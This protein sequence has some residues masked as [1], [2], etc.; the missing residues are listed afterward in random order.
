MLN[1][2]KAA[3][4]TP[5]KIILGVVSSVL[6]AVGSLVMGLGGIILSVI[7]GS[8]SAIMKILN[9]PLTSFVGSIIKSLLGSL[10]KE[11]FKG[12]VSLGPLL[13]SLTV[14]MAAALGAIGIGV[15]AIGSAAYVQNQ[16]MQ[17]KALH[18]GE[19]TNKTNEYLSD[20]EYSNEL[21]KQA[22]RDGTGS[23]S[24]KRKR[25]EE[26]EAQYAKNI[27]GLKGDRK[28]QLERRE[29]AI[30]TPAMAAIG[31]FPKKP[32]GKENDPTYK[33]LQFPD[34][35]LKYF[36]KDENEA[37]REDYIRALEPP[38]VN[39]GSMLEKMNKGL[40]GLVENNLNP[41]SNKIGELQ[42][43][44]KLRIDNMGKD[45]KDLRS[46]FQKGYDEEM[47]SLNSINSETNNV[48]G[49]AKLLSANPMAVRH[50][51]VAIQ[52]VQYTG[53]VSV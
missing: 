37:S 41:L 14:P 50:R 5:F 36:D 10:F 15:A 26:L 11:L 18:E 16:Q 12:L 20:F 33:F 38:K 53:S 39:E 6:G 47:E 30:V 32:E 24:E 2:I 46:D 21:A 43:D 45:F 4:F 22:V 51:H 28:F 7:E 31:F 23:S 35:R 17:K 25:I 9:N 44:T 27:A 52:K 40:E 3:I 42:S 29:Q 13:A 34:G 48:S 1:G 49:E 8:I 19:D